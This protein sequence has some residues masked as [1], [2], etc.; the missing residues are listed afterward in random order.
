[1]TKHE[2][3]A[4]F[5]RPLCTYVCDCEQI[6]QAMIA[7]KFLGKFDSLKVWQTQYPSQRGHTCWYV[8]FVNKEQ[9]YIL[10]INIFLGKIQLEFRYPQYLPDAIRN[11]LTENSK[12]RTANSDEYLLKELE[13]FLRTYT[14]TI[15][16]DFDEDKIKYNKWHIRQTETEPT[17]V[18]HRCP[19]P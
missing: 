11:K 3:I 2:N 16:K 4:E 19:F 6:P 17:C 18:S 15:R 13:D 9:P 12:W 14:E 5:E 7:A 10:N 8:S 1:M